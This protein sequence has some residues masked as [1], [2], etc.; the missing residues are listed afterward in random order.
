MT[1]SEADTSPAAE[2]RAQLWLLVL[3]TQP[4]HRRLGRHGRADTPTASVPE[5]IRLLQVALPVVVHRQG[6]AAQV[7]TP[8]RL[9]RQEPLGQG[10]L[11]PEADMATV[12]LELQ[13]ELQAEPLQAAVAPVPAARVAAQA[14]LPRARPALDPA[15]EGE[16]AA[17]VVVLLRVLLAQGPAA[18]VVAAA[19]V[20]GP[21]RVP[22][23]RD[24]VAAVVAAA[25]A[26]V[27]VVAVVESEKVDALIAA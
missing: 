2:I 4:A 6:Q 7:D 19:A 12:Q 24:R 1:H 14:E 11:A 5:P 27:A 9:Q 10:P 22:L 18:V 8:G 21:P 25:V 15:E 16:A 3:G 23:A 26:A 17:A 20:A 13:P